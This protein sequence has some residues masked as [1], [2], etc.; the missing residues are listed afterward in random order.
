MQFATEICRTEISNSYNSADHLK[1][2]NKHMRDIFME[3]YCQQLHIW[4]TKNSQIKFKL[5]EYSED[6]QKYNIWYE[7]QESLR[8]K[9]KSDICYAYIIYAISNIGTGYQ[10]I[11]YKE[12][13]PNSYLPF[14]PEPN[15]TEDTKLHN[16][17][18]INIM[19]M[20]NMHA[21]TTFVKSWTIYIAIYS[22]ETLVGPYKCRIDSLEKN[23][24]DKI[25]L[26]SKKIDKVPHN[27][28]EFEEILKSK[29]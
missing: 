4:K 6:L 5:S 29:K 27:L 10:E 26:W 14:S 1:I 17:G 15:I 9:N 11:L 7:K 28:A 21:N 20:N 3:F 23:K 16:I 25:V 8:I 22:F 19:Y 2:F 12:Y 24:I 18:F 13:R